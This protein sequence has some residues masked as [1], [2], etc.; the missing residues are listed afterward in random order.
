MFQP[1]PGPS[2]T[3]A[4]TISLGDGQFMGGPLPANFLPPPLNWLRGLDADVQC[5]QRQISLH[6]E[7]DAVPKK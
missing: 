6:A 5:T 7:V 2:G 1:G 4:T 3:W